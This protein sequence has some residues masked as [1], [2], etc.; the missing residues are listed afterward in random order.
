MIICLALLLVP[1][2]ASSKIY[3]EA[4]FG[5]DNQ[6]CFLWWPVLPSTTGWKHDEAASRELSSNVLVPA[7][8]TFQEAP[9]VMYA[10]AMYKPRSP[11]THSLAEFIAGDREETENAVPGVRVAEQR[12]LHDGDGRMLR[13]IAYTAAGSSDLIVYGE[14][15]DFWLVFA[16]SCKSP[17]ALARARSTFEQLVAR[18]KKTP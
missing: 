7:G 3:K 8:Q 6:L 1:A 10:R 14:E 2:V 13:C 11:E 9:A 17:S 18:Y 16:V 5:A 15:D 4:V 12:P